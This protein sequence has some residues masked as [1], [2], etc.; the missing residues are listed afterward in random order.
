MANYPFCT[1][2]PNKA[3][4]PVPDPRLDRLAALVPHDSVTPCDA[5]IRRHRRAGQGRE[6]K[7]EGLGNQFLG[8]IRDVAA[9]VHVVRC[10]TDPNVVHVSP[11]PQPRDD[12]EVVELELMLADLQ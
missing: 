3:I 1:I 7:G 5:R 9:I 10:F 4:V 12:I 11:T 2:Q 6:S 8:N